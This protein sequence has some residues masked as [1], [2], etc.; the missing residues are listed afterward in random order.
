MDDEKEAVSI[1]PP[2]FSLT[3]VF[4]TIGKKGFVGALEDTDKKVRKLASDALAGFGEA[5]RA[6][7]RAVLEETEAEYGRRRS[8]L[9]GVLRTLGEDDRDS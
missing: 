7:I 3:K 9:N 6:H 1:T 5:A 2:K 4:S 8:I